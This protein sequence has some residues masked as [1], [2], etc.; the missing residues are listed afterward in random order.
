M[1][2]IYEIETERLLLRQWRPSDFPTFAQ[3]SAD[4]EVMRFFPSPLNEQQ[5]NDMAQRCSDLID[6][7][8]WGFWAAQERSCCM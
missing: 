8:G 5:S 3:M 1:A 6:L 2:Q 4:K 7:R